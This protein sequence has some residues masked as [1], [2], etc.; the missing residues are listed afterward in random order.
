MTEHVDVLIVGAGLSGIGAACRIR[1]EHPE[2]S[3]AVL[4]GRDRSGG[5]WDL[6][7][8]PG[9]RSDSDMYTLGYQWRP[10]RGDKALAD[11]PSILAYVRQ[12]AEEYGVDALI[13]Y[14]HRV[15]AASWDTGTARWTVDV[16]VGGERR[17]L[18]A[19]FLWGCS[20]YYDYDQGYAPEFPGQE[21]FAGQVVHPQHWPEDLDYSGKK[22]VVIGSG[23]TAV[24]LVPAMADRTEHI[25]MLQRSPT[26]VLSMPG[27]DPLA[28]KL[29]KLPEKVAFP[30]VR[31]KSILV[32]MASYG[33]SR[34]RPDVLRG[35]IRK[36][37][38]RM[39]PD[40]IDVDTHFKPTYDP[41]DQ[42]LCLVPDG[43]LFRAFRKGTASIVT[44]TIETFTET[45]IRLTSGQ[46]LEAD[47]IVTA[48]G[49]NL[50]AFG[51][52]DL[53][54]DGEPVKVSQ[55]MAYKALMLSG[56]PNF[57]FT[58]GYTNASWTLKADLVADYVC[59][60]L[61]HLDENGLRYA[62]P[63]AD[64]GMA[65]EPFMDF[66]SGYVLRA[67]DTLPKQ[68]DRAPWKLKQNYLTDL[69]T[70]RKTDIDD[71]VLEMA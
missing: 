18:T 48:T 31:W 64:P 58:I 52:I 68:G 39:L 20:G 49:L 25:T 2:R 35:F 9:V 8:Y 30:I 67:L 5:T 12:V 47:I 4:E 65:Q 28:Q 66:Q 69:R 26:Y 11:G 1:E 21:N 19:G 55:T 6:F 53:T 60:L 37:T 33:L 57:A 13:R 22:V 71:G 10:W 38:E 27:R 43:D 50:K 29:S 36:N 45:G 56:V 34:K 51:G 7:R 15:V 61:R 46:E 62:V 42:R 40:H 44:D 3:V 41:W 14:D 32:A 23:A 16:E 17:Q 70:I 54:V 63:V 59:R 24:T